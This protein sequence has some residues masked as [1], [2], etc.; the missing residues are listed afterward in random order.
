[1]TATQSKIKL[2]FNGVS[3][4]V[5][6]M[7][8]GLLILTDEAK[9]RQI[10]IVCDKL[11]AVQIELRARRCL[12][13]NLLPEVLWKTITRMSNAPAEINITGVNDGQ[14][15][16]VACFGPDWIEPVAI[17]A[18]DAVL[19]SI[20]ANAPIYINADLMARQSV[21]YDKD[22]RGVALPVNTIS[23]DMLQSA[24]DKAIIEEN[25]E[26]AARL[27]DEQLRRGASKDPKHSDKE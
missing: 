9:E 1:M 15:H 20:I 18:S 24:L 26:L 2:I 27:R 25:Y 19:L 17:R 16:V 12:T 5:G 11:A 10:T 21:P 3:E 7:Q 6:T 8:L 14:Y 13:S 23:N 22:A 4:I